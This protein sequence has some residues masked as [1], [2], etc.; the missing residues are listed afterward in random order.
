M[1][2]QMKSDNL[3]GRAILVNLA[4]IFLLDVMGLIIKHLSG[5][6]GAAELS[7]YR[8]LFGLI[9]SLTVLAMSA[10]WRAGGCRLGLRQWPLACLR[11]AFVAVAQFM[12]YLS[13]ARLAFATATT[14][15][16]SMSLFA[17][18]L[19]VP[20][21]GDRVGWVRWAAVM[22]G[23]AGVAMVIGPGS[24]S[25]SL[26][27][28]LPVGAAT[29][30]ALTAV[31]SRLF[32]GDV[33]TPLVN[34]YSTGAAALGAIVLCLGTGGFT[35]IAANSDLQWRAV[36]GRLVPDDRAEQSGAVQLFRHPVRLRPGL[37]VLRRGAGRA[38][39]PGR[40]A[41]RR[42]R[43]ADR[44]AREAGSQ[45]CGGGRAEGPVGSH[46]S[47]ALAR[48]AGRAPAFRHRQR[49]SGR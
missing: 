33:P 16:F 32:D 19:S 2:G 40:P 11:G 3:V 6:Y 12:F 42:R 30:Y 17:V 45:A 34:L 48:P 1:A 8:N 44:L 46:P 47:T 15:A 29:F 26:D 4:G 27:A 13:L 41:D 9:P 35:P 21:L 20:I 36:P 49:R 22:V 25:F 14:I 28:L 24:D 7:V 37:G 5:G 39:V 31:T 10:S 23:F 43:V 18:A 38:A